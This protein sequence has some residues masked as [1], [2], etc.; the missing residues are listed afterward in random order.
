MLVEVAAGPEQ[1]SQRRTSA[2]CNGASSR[3]GCSSRSAWWVRKSASARR[4]SRLRSRALHETK[5][6]IMTL[7][8]AFARLVARRRLR[9]PRPWSRAA[10]TRPRPRIAEARAREDEARQAERAAKPDASGKSRGRPARKSARRR[11]TATRTARRTATSAAR[12]PSTTGAW[13]RAIDAVR[14]RD[15]GQGPAGRRRAL[16][17][18]LCEEQAGP[19]RRGLEAPGRARPSVPAEPL[20]EGG[21]GPRGG[22]PPAVGAAH[23]PRERGRRGP[24]ADGHQRP[25]Q[26]RRRARDPHAREDSSGP[27][28]AQAAGAGALRPDPE[29]LAA[30]P[31]DRGADRQGRRAAGS[32]AAGDPAARGVRGQG[33]PAR[34]SPRSTRRAPTGA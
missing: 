23:A 3:A 16:L 10:R 34:P 4:P 2:S 28:V 27:R 13:D 14:R 26:H 20:A 17:E 22:D 6:E 21:R 32:S 9:I 12:K 30:G 19:A 24:E 25:A 1:L 11:K 8:I 33:E 29:Q 31:R 7:G 15:R 18:G 5:D